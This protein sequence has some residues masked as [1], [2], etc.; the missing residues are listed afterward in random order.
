MGE[1]RS[2]FNISVGKPEVRNHLEDL[3]LDR[4]TI[5]EEILGK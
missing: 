3:G 2:A 5:L 4:T 1:M